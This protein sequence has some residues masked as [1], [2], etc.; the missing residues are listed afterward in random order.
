[1]TDKKPTYKEKKGTTRVGDFLRSIGRSDILSKVLKGSA[2]LITG[3]IGG[4]IQV[5]LENEMNISEQDKR[6]AFAL[7]ELD[8]KESEE[9]TKRWEADAKA[10]SW[11]TRSVRPIIALYS[12]FVTS[13]FTFIV[14]F[15]DYKIEVIWVDLWKT[16][17]VT[18]IVAYFGS[19]GY[20]KVIEKKHIQK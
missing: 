16:T 8:I 1:M 18:I 6:Y 20:E 7:L 12:V 5:I 13:F 4:A 9:V 19:R 11:L 2:E 3:D 17:L 14:L 15:T 10:D